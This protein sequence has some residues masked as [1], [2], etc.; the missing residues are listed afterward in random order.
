MRLILAVLLLVLVASPSFAEDRE[1]FQA[2]LQKFAFA[3]PAE[4]INRAKAF[5]RCGGS[6]LVGILVQTVP[7][8]ND[9]QVFLACFVPTFSSDSSLFSL[10]GCAP[11]EILK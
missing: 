4:P 5:C 9:E 3:V 2:K 7:G 6:E 1:V 10:A 11:F 8:I